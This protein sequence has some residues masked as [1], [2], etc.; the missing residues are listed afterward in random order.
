MFAR[1]HVSDLKLSNNWSLIV[2]FGWWRGQV[3]KNLDQS[4]VER[5]C[6]RCQ[7]SISSH[8][9]V[10]PL[11]IATTILSFSKPPYPIVIEGQERLKNLLAIFLFSNGHPSIWEIKLW[12]CRLEVIS[13]RTTTLGQVLKPMSLHLAF[14]KR[15]H[16][17]KDR[18]VHSTLIE[19]LEVFWL[20]VFW[21][22]HSLDYEVILIMKIVKFFQRDINVYWTLLKAFQRAL[23]RYFWSFR[24]FLLTL[25]LRSRTSIELLRI[26]LIPNWLWWYRKAKFLKWG[27]LKT[28]QIA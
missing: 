23:W 1:K 2:F 20:R 7:R 11:Y 22:F 26:A 6:H 14:R 15:S 13:C 5:P 24:C 28:H 12:W 27:V 4:K 9:G 25:H 8:D 3:N 16:H 21:L 18:L 19:R 17:N 10:R